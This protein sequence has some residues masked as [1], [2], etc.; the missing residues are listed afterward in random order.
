MTQS[1]NRS[2]HWCL[3]I[4]N[5]D[6]EAEDYYDAQLM[7]YF[8]AGFERAP[9]TRTIHYQSYVCWKKRMSFN[10]TKKYF[11]EAHIERMRGTC[12]QAIT[13]CKKDD[14]WEAFGIEPI[15]PAASAADDMQARWDN[16]YALAKEGKFEEI[17]KDMLI[18]YY[19][20]FKRIFQDNPPKVAALDC[21]CGIW[22]SGPTGA[23]KSHRARQLDPKLFDKQ[24]NKWWDGYLGEDTVLLDDLDDSHAKWIPHFLKRWADKYPFPAEIKGTTVRIRPKRIIVTS[25]YTPSDVF[26]GRHLAAINRRFTH[27]PMTVADRFNESSDD[28]SDDTSAT[29]EVLSDEPPPIWSSQF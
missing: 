9:K 16:A 11:P 3:T 1:Q 29:E 17:P 13:Y 15:T 28:D 5:P 14:D 8:I 26:D 6:F 10:Q 20:A 19:H 27:I 24:I 22:I 7:D 18:M 4:N 2:R 25:Q 12:T 23:G 21:V